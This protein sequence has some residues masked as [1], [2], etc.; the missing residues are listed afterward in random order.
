MRLESFNTL[1]H[2]QFFGSAPRI[3]QLGAKFGF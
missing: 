2:A 1:N 3:V